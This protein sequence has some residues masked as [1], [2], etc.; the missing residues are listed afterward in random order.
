MNSIN[1][2]NKIEL[3][4]LIITKIII[5][6]ISSDFHYK[7]LMLIILF[8][9]ILNYENYDNSIYG[10]D[11]IFSFKNKYQFVDNNETIN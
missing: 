6:L 9:R 8:Y 2:N 4:I 1:N 5:N 11:K 3:S 7:F 10:C